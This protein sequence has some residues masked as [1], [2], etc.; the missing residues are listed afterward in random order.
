MGAS[1]SGK[2]TLVRQLKIAHEGADAGEAARY[3]REARKVALD[4]VKQGAKEVSSMLSS[5]DLVAAAQRLE[6]LGRRAQIKG[7]VVADVRKL[8]SAPEV[9]SYE[10]KAKD[11]QKSKARRHYVARIEVLAEPDYVPEPLDLLHMAIPTVGQTETRIRSFPGGELTLI[12]VSDEVSRSSMVV[13]DA[14]SS[15]VCAHSDTAPA[16]STWSTRLRTT[17]S[18]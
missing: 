6:A 7:D 3:T 10:E 18:H 12:E 13:S 5:A 1:S 17:G 15:K 8:W 9:V 14:V 16:D 4:L 11:V 2:S